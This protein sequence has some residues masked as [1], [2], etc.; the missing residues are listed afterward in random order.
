M[1]AQPIFFLGG[2]RGLKIFFSQK[3]NKP[4]KFARVE[5]KFIL[6]WLYHEIFFSFYSFYS[7]F[8]T[9]KT[10]VCHEIKKI[11]KIRI[12]DTDL[13]LFADFLNNRQGK[14]Y[15]EVVV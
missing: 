12:T 9:L 1:G 15:E 13:S 4:A 11:K 14:K 10:K 5:P 7:Y 6:N 3:I 2:M 8:Y